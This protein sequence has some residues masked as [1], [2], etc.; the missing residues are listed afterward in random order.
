MSS[1]SAMS[2]DAGAD[3]LSRS[4]C[5]LEAEGDVPVR[6]HVRVQRVVLEDHRHPPLVRRLVGDVAVA[7]EDAPAID[8]LEA[9]EQAQRGRL[10][11]PRGPEERDE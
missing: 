5:Q 2:R 4:T 11:A 3:L 9:G 1:I 10:A 8:L 6:R 7:E